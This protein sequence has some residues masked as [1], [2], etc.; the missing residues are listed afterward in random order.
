MHLDP[1]AGRARVQHCGPAAVVP[2]VSACGRRRL[3]PRC[4]SRRRLASSGVVVAEASVSG[5]ESGIT[6]LATT[7][8]F[9]SAKD[10]CVPPQLPVSSV[11]YVRWLRVRAWAKRTSRVGG[12]F[13]RFLSVFLSHT[14]ITHE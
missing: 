4:S 9:A 2:G 11:Q 7:E 8:G 12:A 13:P 5:K 6:S 3:L 1:S 10:E 14:Q